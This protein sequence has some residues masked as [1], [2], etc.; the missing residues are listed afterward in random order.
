M[1]LSVGLSIGSRSWSSSGASTAGG[2][3]SFTNGGAYPA[4][5]DG[6]SFAVT[7]ASTT[8]N[9]PVNIVSCCAAN[10]MSLEIPAVADG[11]T[12]TISLKGPVDTKSK[13]YTASTAQ[14]PMA[15]ITSSH[16]VSVGSNNI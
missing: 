11:T 12:L 1:T 15:T 14:T 8:M 5:I 13:T 10:S 7:V 4:S 6:L 3:V 16:S 2:L 9:Y